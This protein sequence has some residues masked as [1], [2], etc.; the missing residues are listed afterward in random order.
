LSN[1]AFSDYSAIY[2]KKLGLN[3]VFKNLRRRNFM[4][5]NPAYDM[6]ENI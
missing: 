5:L 2:Y 3:L 6:Q 1:Y 4:M